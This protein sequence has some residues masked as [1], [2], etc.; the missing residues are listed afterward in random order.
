MCFK[1]LNIFT[2]LILICSSI[3]F[4]TNEYNQDTLLTTEKVTRN[5]EVNSDV[6]IT[7]D[8]VVVDEVVN[9]SLFLIG[10]NIKVLSPEVN[11]NV[12]SI[13]NEIEITGTINGSV[14]AISNDVEVAGKIEDLYLITNDLEILGN[15]SCR[16]IKV[17]GNSVE[18]E[19]LVN[20]DLYA[21]S[22]EVNIKN[23]ENSKING[24]L[25]ATG[26]IS[27]RTDKINEISKMDLKIEKNNVFAETFVKVVRTI[28]FI[29]TSVVALLI[30]AIII[31]CT[32]KSDVYKTD[33]QELFFKDTLSGIVCWCV[34]ILITIALCITIIGIPFAIL[35]G[36][37]IWL[38]FWKINLPVASI[39]ISKFIL[40]NNTN[41]KWKMFF[42]A[43]IVFVGIQVIDL[44]PVL[45]SFIKYIVSLYG[46]GY[47]YRKL[48]K[49]DKENKIEVEIVEEN[50]E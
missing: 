28:Y 9:G 4:A 12:F 49:K 14:Y 2:I 50:K 40:K 21:I 45:G 8:N 36:A 7:Q 48:F 32:K 1:V 3:C 47:I 5:N 29:S 42:V 43:F 17:I 6:F 26:N 15:A 16:D 13:G 39:E 11:G 34:C 25:Y 24:I 46:F 44:I 10:D 23:T 41:S 30:I 27:G 35:F 20:R 38:L 18:I 31:L 37:I 19:G 22:N 33:I